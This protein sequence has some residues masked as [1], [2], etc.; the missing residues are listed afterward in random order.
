MTRVTK[1]KPSDLALAKEFKQEAQKILG[2]NLVSVI[3]YG[4]RARGTA[5][6]ESDMDI[7]LL[8]KKEVQRRNKEDWALSEVSGQFL[9]HKD[10]L[11]TAIPYT[12]DDYKKWLRWSPVL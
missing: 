11:V 6:E 10:M 7:L 5:N 12:V 2:D 9:L 8:T 1:A 3:L 4:S